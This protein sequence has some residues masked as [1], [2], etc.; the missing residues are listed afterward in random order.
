MGVV[1]FTNPGAI[2]RATTV[3]NK[4]NTTVTITNAATAVAN[5]DVIAFL[6]GGNHQNLLRRWKY[7]L[8]NELDPDRDAEIRAALQDAL[9]DTDITR[10]EFDVIEGTNQI[11]HT[12][13]EHDFDVNTGVLT[14]KY[15]RI[16]LETPPTKASIA[17]PAA[18]PL[19]DQFS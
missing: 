3:N 8:R 9:E 5:G 4:T 19:D 1:D 7:F 6:G 10:V 14:N 18:I 13:V 2:P 12:A 11:V 16:V 15:I 17:L